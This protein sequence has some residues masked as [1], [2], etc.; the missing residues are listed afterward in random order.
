VYLQAGL[1]YRTIPSRLHV[2]LLRKN[3]SLAATNTPQV[4]SI[5]P[6]PTE[7]LPFAVDGPSTINMTDWPEQY[8]APNCLGERPFVAYRTQLQ[9]LLHDQPILLKI[10]EVDSSGGVAYKGFAS[11]SFAYVRNGLV[12]PS[13]QPGQMTMQNLRLR[14]LPQG[15]SPAELA[16]AAQLPYMLPPQAWTCLIWAVN[17]WVTLD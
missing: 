8:P 14:E 12:M 15:G 1:S 11:L 7:D 3:I 16:A 4:S 6:P 9:G 10:P 17:R 2:L 13:E 5:T